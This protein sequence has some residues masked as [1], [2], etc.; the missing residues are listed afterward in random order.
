MT[1]VLKI[2][3]FLQ[4][5]EEAATVNVNVSEGLITPTKVVRDL[6]FSL[7]IYEIF[8]VLFRIFET[9]WDFLRI[10]FEEA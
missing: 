1:E 10:S 7:G 4:K 6:G 3:R 9:F 8:Q 5:D 2:C